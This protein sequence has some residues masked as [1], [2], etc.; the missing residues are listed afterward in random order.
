MSRSNFTYSN[1][2]S[3]DSLGLSF[4]VKKKDMQFKKRICRVIEHCL[5]RRTANQSERFAQI[6]VPI[7]DHSQ[8]D[9]TDPRNFLNVSWVIAIVRN[10]GLSIA[11]GENDFYR[12][13]DCPTPDTYRIQTSGFTW[14]DKQLLWEGPVYVP[15]TVYRPIKLTYVTYVGGVCRLNTN[16]SQTRLW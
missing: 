5:G 8:K 16:D 10:T 9:I 3:K 1:T 14:L 4:S 15:P 7:T 11:G 12:F 2:P 13:K 6:T